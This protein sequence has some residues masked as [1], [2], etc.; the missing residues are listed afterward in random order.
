MPAPTDTDRPW[1][2]Q[3]GPPGQPPAAPPP[4][5]LPPEGAP[6]GLPNDAL[7]LAL[8]GGGIRSATFCLGVLQALAR[9]GWLR[10]VDFLSTVSGGGYVGA[11][12][13]RFFD[14]ARRRDGVT[15]AIPDDS[16]G[17]GQDRVARDLVD[18]RSE[19]IEW[20]R[21]H[22]N[23]LSPTGHGEMANNVAGFWRNLTSVYVVL[24][25]FLLA[26]FGLLNALAYWHPEGGVA[27]ALAEVTK[28]LTPLTG[29][30]GLKGPWALLAELLLWCAVF[31]LMIAY[32]LV[33]QDLPE[34]FLAPV[35]AAS[36][37]LSVAVVFATGSVLG[38]V[39]FA[40]SVVW[41]LSVWGTV[42]R[43][44]AHTDP[45]NPA[46]LNLAR[47]YL[48][49]WLARWFAIALGIAAFALVDAL[50]RAL[51]HRMMTGGLTVPNVT[52]WFASVG[53]SVLGI[54][55]GLR[56]AVRVL[57]GESPRGAGALAFARPYLAAALILLFGLVPPLV[58]LAF[59]SHAA[60][61]LGEMYT[62][63]LVLTG[64]ALGASRLFGTTPCVPFINRSGPIGIYTS[65][66]ARAFLGAVN[67]LRRAH[68]EGKN[69]THAVPGDDVP[70]SDYAPHAAG[71]PL[72]VI[73]CAVN[74]TVD[75]ASKRA[76][77]D[78]Q[79]EPMAVG[80]AGVSVATEW[81]ALWTDARRATLDPLADPGE[82]APHPFL[83]EKGGAVSVEGLTLQQWI[84]IS[85][86]ALGP[87]MGRRTGAARALLLTLVNLR[88]GYW[89]NSGLDARERA[90][91]PGTRAAWR[92]LLACFTTLFYAQ[93]LILAELSARFAGPWERY[94]HLSDGGHFENTGAYELLR[95]RV[96]FVIV[97]DAGED[98]GHVGSDLA[99]LVRLVRVD[100]GA[101]VEEVA[102]AALPPGVPVA[103]G[104]RLGPVSDVLA[105]RAHAALLC[106]R[107]PEPP[108][109]FNGDPW[110]AR[111]H[112]WVLY[113]K[114][115]VTGGEPDDVRNYAALNPDFPN[116]TTLDQM[117]DEPQWES[118][119]ALG[120][121]I[122]TQ[123]F[124]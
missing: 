45:F 17:A 5:A 12:L 121:H 96:P 8:S 104:A 18:S 72:H 16:P 51:A 41:A 3:L 109:H 38:F 94:W 46:R 89:W 111:R 19:P 54:V 55:L 82:A 118:Y 86:A 75:V 1:L 6:A 73:N 78:R 57:V 61:A 33:S 92:R 114:A 81:H 20:L 101:T 113:L 27:G 105:S 90:F 74:E 124:T 63:G 50:G 10:A 100:L 49:A 110:L 56:V 59:V 99:R 91:V 28:E 120:E 31:P 48:T 76:L 2:V 53:A 44:E 29:A 93:A 65:R 95:R 25:L 64:V 103:V 70:L 22:A 69:V 79:A 123:L 119:R 98:R 7:G 85:G 117:F 88:L 11:F 77:K 106:V 42:A 4:A 9:S 13:G 24:A 14:Q 66:L 116:E 107:Y 23:Y 34:T 108:A 37:I 71:G 112:T 68:P 60:Y 39:V 47:N 87:G 122:G 80:P 30:L 62:Q 26:A 32:W 43:E 15:G 36:A 52:A 102:P 83:S 35:L 67:P 21:K 58:A 97:C 115:A 40:A 84:A